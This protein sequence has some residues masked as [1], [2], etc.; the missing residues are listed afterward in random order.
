MTTRYAWP[1]LQ[2]YV[3]Q[4]QVNLYYSI[5]YVSTNKLHYSKLFTLFKARKFKFCHSL[6]VMGPY[7]ESNGFSVVSEQKHYLK[8]ISLY[9]I[10]EIKSY[11]VGT[12]WW[13]VFIF[14]FHHHYRLLP[15]ARVL[16]THIQDYGL[17]CLSLYGWHFYYFYSQKNSVLGAKSWILTVLAQRSECS[18]CS[19][20]LHT[21]L[22]SPTGWIGKFVVVS[23]GEP[24]SWVTW[25]GAVPVRTPSFTAGSTA[26]ARPELDRSSW[27][28]SSHRLVSAAA[29]SVCFIA[30]RPLKAYGWWRPGARLAASFCK[31]FHE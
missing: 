14:G 26:L 19:P 2:W 24:S 25:Y 27:Q 18:N 16:I 30:V 9:S 15:Q 20:L 10:K 12:T 17:N 5:S 21:F 8:Y 7:I 3:Y 6:W 22:T 1:S 11:R 4:C 13:W 31:S 28:R 23:Y 29:K